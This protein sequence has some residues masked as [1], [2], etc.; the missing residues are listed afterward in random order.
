MS[1]ALSRPDYGLKAYMLLRAFGRTKY[2]D[3]IEQNIDQIHYLA[4][5]IKKEPNLEITLPVVSNVVCFRYKRDGYS[6]DCDLSFT[7]C[8]YSIKAIKLV[9]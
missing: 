9:R 8:S 4:D 7:L 6:A 2:S 1:L 3:L 5:Q